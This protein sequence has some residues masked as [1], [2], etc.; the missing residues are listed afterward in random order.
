MIFKPFYRTRGNTAPGSGLGLTIAKKQANR[1][2]GQ[3]IARNTE[4]GLAF[5]IRLP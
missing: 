5:E 1:C 3:I 4:S 2:K